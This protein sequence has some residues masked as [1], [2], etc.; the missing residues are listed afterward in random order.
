[1]IA[2]PQQGLKEDLFSIVNTLPIASSDLTSTHVSF[3]EINCMGYIYQ[4]RNA[5][6]RELFYKALLKNL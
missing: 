5:A 1:M 6:E 2:S 4:N 3:Y